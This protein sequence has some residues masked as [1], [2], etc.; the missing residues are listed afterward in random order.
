[1]IYH[2]SALDW[3]H[4]QLRAHERSSQ[5]DYYDDTDCFRLS[6]QVIWSGSDISQTARVGQMLRYNSITWKYT[7]EYEAE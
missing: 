1:M 4:Y 5:V 2:L 6:V 3:K 7:H